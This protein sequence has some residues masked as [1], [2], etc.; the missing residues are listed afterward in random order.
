[1]RR[2][3]AIERKAA[4]LHCNMKGGWNVT[5]VALDAWFNK[6]GATAPPQTRRCAGAALP[7]GSRRARPDGRWRARHR[8]GADPPGSR[9]ALR[10]MLPPPDL[11]EGRRQ[12]GD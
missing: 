2:Q 11:D 8:L 6:V 9:A 12:T 5:G 10:R 3:S 7:A 4:M 1:M